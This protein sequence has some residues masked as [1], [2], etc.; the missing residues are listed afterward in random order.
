M[1]FIAENYYDKMSKILSDYRIICD[2]KKTKELYIEIMDKINE[3]LEYNLNYTSS[4]TI[5]IRFSDEF[6]NK[7]D[8]HSE[9]CVKILPLMTYIS[10]KMK[11]HGFIGTVAENNSGNWSLSINNKIQEDYIKFIDKPI[12]VCIK[13]VWFPSHVFDVSYLFKDFIKNENENINNI[14]DSKRYNSFADF[15]ISSDNS[16]YY[17][18]KTIDNKHIESIQIMKPHIN[19]SIEDI[20]KSIQ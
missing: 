19:R 15:I 4:N 16:I 13:Q 2:T 8:N 17:L 11:Q 12:D 5:N 7:Y 20:I 1:T 14:H 3:K 10:R 6:L 18:R 9:K